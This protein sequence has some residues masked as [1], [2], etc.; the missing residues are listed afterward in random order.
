MREQLI[1]PMLLG[2]GAVGGAL[3]GS[4]IALLLHRR[5][6]GPP[7]WW[8]SRCD[9]YT[10]CAIVHRY[11]LLPVVVVTI[12]L[13]RLHRTIQNHPQHIRRRPSE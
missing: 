4:L 1:D 11:A 6:G 2:I 13:I 12:S 9:Q 3:A 7:I 10:G 8:T 5:R